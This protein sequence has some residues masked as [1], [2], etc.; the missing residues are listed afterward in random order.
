MKTATTYCNITQMSVFMID[1]YF[2]D[3]REKK[4]ITE[5]LDIDTNRTTGNW[6]SGE[7]KIIYS[8]DNLY[9]P[10]VELHREYTPL[11]LVFSDEPKIIN[12]T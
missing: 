8:V 10:R 3:N 7:L 2:S 12:Q 1:F 11:F 5:K 4:T 6:S 9:R